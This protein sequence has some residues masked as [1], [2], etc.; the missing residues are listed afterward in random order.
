MSAIDEKSNQ[1]SATTTDCYLNLLEE[2]QPKPEEEID[3]EKIRFFASRTSIWDF[4]GIPL[5][6]YLAYSRKEK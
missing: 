2:P 3:E 6:K 4:Y 1:N 5:S